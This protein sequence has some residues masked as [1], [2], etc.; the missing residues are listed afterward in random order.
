MFLFY[1]LLAYILYQVVFRFVLPLYRT[2]KQVRRTFRDMQDGM[3]GQPAQH[4]GGGTAPKPKQK[5]IG[6][7][8]DFEEVK[9]K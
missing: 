4:Q 7:Y 8:I 2:T 9:E 5:P 1:F 6:D 3:G